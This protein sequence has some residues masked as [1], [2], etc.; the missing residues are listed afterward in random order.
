MVP[1]Q[2]FRMCQILFFRHKKTPFQ[3]GREPEQLRLIEKVFFYGERT[4]SGTHEKVS[5]VV[6]I[7]ERRMAMAFKRKRSPEAACFVPDGSGFGKRLFR[8]ADETDSVCFL[9]LDS[10]SEQ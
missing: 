2:P 1:T 8:H 6:F 5:R 9:R 3:C 7:V 4:T 10:W